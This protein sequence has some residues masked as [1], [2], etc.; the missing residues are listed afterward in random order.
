MV[1][2]YVAK[3]KKLFRYAPTLMVEEGIPAKKFE[4]KLRDWIQQLANDYIWVATYKEVVNKALVI[5]KGL[6][7]AQAV[8]EKV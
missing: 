7:I 4:N 5:E 8:I 2:Q 6:D 3:F 1:T